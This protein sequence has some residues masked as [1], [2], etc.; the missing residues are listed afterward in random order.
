MVRL[1]FIAMLFLTPLF[2]DKPSKIIVSGTA[3]IRMEPDLLTALLGVETTAKEAQ[4]AIDE[5][6]DKMAKVSS[7]LIKLGLSDKDLATQNYLLSP[8]YALPPKNPPP[9]YEPKIIGY[10]VKNTLKI[11]T[12]HIDWAGKIIDQASKEGGNS[13]EQILFSLKKEDAGKQEALKKA[14]LEAESYAKA[15]SEAA[16]IS[17][18]PI[19]EIS[20]SSPYITP[21]RLQNAALAQVAGTPIFPKEVEVSATVNV[22]YSISPPLSEKT[23]K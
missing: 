13:V 18:G 14:Y 8:L 19:L 7:A 3:Q 5:N 6:R 11:E 22:T 12:S 17:L 23:G 10:K 9:D 2:A 20:I 15:L 16:N 4:G 21:F 1:F